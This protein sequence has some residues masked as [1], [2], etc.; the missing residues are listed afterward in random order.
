MLSGT[1]APPIPQGL[2]HVARLATES[3]A[4]KNVGRAT[5]AQRAPIASS[6]PMLLN[7]VF[8]DQTQ[9]QLYIDTFKA[10]NPGITI[11]TELTEEQ[12]DRYNTILGIANRLAQ[13]SQVRDMFHINHQ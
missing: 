5:L 6:R 1:L 3:L 7:V 4:A 13:D 9:R 2:F 12:L 10:E 8:T 11:P